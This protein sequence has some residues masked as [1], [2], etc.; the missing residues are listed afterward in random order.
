MLGSIMRVTDSPSVSLTFDDGPH[1]DITPAVLEILARHGA[2]ATFFVL[3]EPAA[4]HRSLLAETV[5]AGHEIAL[6]GASHAR[7]TGSS[8]VVRREVVDG[9]AE[10]EDLLG[11]SVRWFRPSFGEQTKASFALARRAGLQVVL[12][13]VDTKDYLDGDVDE[14]RE[15]LQGGFTPGAIVLAHDVPTGGHER[16]GPDEAKLRYLEWVLDAIGEVTSTIV[17]VTDLVS[18]GHPKRSTHFHRPR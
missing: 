4:R 12:W 1:P 8:D 10:L 2:R 18:A 9:K 17:T 11:S 3:T 15:R 6:H 14:R 16:S 5:A 13:S 7:L